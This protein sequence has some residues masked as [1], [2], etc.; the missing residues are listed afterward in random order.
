V[1]T[2]R[3][4]EREFPG[5]WAAVK[6][7]VC[8]ISEKHTADFYGPGKVHVSVKPATVVYIPTIPDLAQVVLRELVHDKPRPYQIECFVHAAL[9]NTIV[10]LPTGA[11]KTLIA[12]MLASFMHRLNPTKTVL[13]V[14]ER[15]PLAFQQGQYFSEQTSLNV[16][17]ACGTV[18]WKSHGFRRE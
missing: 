11:G 5:K 2:L 7:F 10:Y 18:C 14:V 17:I 1:T 13:F 3:Q 8:G 9:R 15:V 12:A 16:L 6:R 4:G